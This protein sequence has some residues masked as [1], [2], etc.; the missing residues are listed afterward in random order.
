MTIVMSHKQL[1]SLLALLSLA[2]L[3]APAAPFGSAFTYQGQLQQSNI[4]VNGPCDLQFGLWDSATGGTQLG[5]NETFSAVSVSNGVFTVILDFGLAAFNG[6]ARWLEIAVRAPAGSGEFTLLAPRQ[7]LTATPYALQAATAVQVPA[8]NLTGTLSDAQIPTNITRLNL[9]QTFAGS[10][11]FLGASILTNSNNLFAGIFNGSFFGDGSGLTNLPSGGFSSNQPLSWTTVSV[12]PQQA[13]PN[14]GYLARGAAQVTITLPTSPNLGDIVRVAGA[15]TGG[16]R[17]LQGADGQVILTQPL[18][19]AAGL[20]WTSNGPLAV[21]RGLACSA[22]GTKVIAVARSGTIGLSTDS[23]QTWSTTSRGGEW[24]GVACSADGTKAVAGGVSGGIWTSADSGANW[25]PHAASVGNLMGFA[26]SA[27]GVRLMAV[28]QGSYIYLSTDSGA[29]WTPKAATKDWSCVACSTDG[30]RVVA[31]GHNT[32][33]FVSLDGG[34]TYTQHGPTNY[35]TG[36]AS[37]ADGSRLVAVGGTA[38]ISSQIYV[39]T[40][41]GN[42]WAARGPTTNSWAG[43]ASS[44]DGSR[45]FAVENGMGQPPYAGSIYIST[46]S[47]TTWSARGPQQGW[48]CIT[49]SANGTKAVAAAAWPHDDGSADS[50]TGAIFTSSGTTTPGISGGLLGGRNEAVEL[51]YMGFNEF[52]VLSHEGTI[53]SF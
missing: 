53:N 4:P 51:L 26:S 22:D 9:D 38:A 11:L 21:W 10:N 35:W 13:A 34:L 37:S 30:M 52:R 5:T 16:W 39:S 1:F 45:L 41:Y 3:A 15:S 40:D 19:C 42:T 20:N 25:T 12:G 6:D 24:D 46:D 8:T 43:V 29:S 50:H 2:S 36:I 44:A 32:P 14:N 48:H 18:G 31:A 28:S 47:G 23:G 17:I 33:V 49:T 7:L 27:D